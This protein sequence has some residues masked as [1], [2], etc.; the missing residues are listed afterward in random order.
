MFCCGDNSVCPSPTLVLAHFSKNH[1]SDGIH[2]G[3][4]WQRQGKCRRW[5]R[6][7][8]VHRIPIHG[9]SDGE[10]VDRNSCVLQ[11]FCR[12]GRIGDVHR[13]L[14]VGHQ[15]AVLFRAA[16][17]TGGG[18]EHLS[19]H[20]QKRVGDVGARKHTADDDRVEDAPLVLVLVERKHDVRRGAERHV[21]HLVLSVLEREA[22]NDG[23]HHRE[24]DGET[25]DFQT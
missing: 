3:D 19:E 24:V 5:R 1:F 6:G 16:P 25:V 4:P 22:F 20:R 2:V 9:L 10:R 17:G 13:R 11:L 21:R 18:D 14:P 15:E 12:C 8:R 7:D 23:G